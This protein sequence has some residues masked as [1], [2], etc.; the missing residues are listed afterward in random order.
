[1]VF[2]Y[3]RL[4]LDSFTPVILRLRLYVQLYII[5]TIILNIPY[6]KILFI[7]NYAQSLDQC[8]LIFKTK[9]IFHLTI[10]RGVSSPLVYKIEVN[11]RYKYQKKYESRLPYEK[12]IRLH[13]THLSSS[14]FTERFVLN[15]FQT[16]ITPLGFC[17]CLSDKSL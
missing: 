10:Y 9:T 3:F 1:M 11:V 4:S 17:L 15:N 13:P 2:I 7:L 8:M 14:Q 6:P 5:T 16:L 12:S